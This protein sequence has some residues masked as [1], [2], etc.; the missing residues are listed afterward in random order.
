MRSFSYIYPF[1]PDSLQGPGQVC[2][3]ICFS[4]GGWLYYLSEIGLLLV[5]RTVQAPLVSLFFFFTQ[6]N[7]ICCYRYV[8][9]LRQVYHPTIM[10]PSAR[11][12][13]DNPSIAPRE[14]PAFKIIEI[15]FASSLSPSKKPS[16]YD[17]ASCVVWLRGENAL[18]RQLLVFW[19]H[20]NSF[21]YLDQMVLWHLQS[22]PCFS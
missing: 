20:D 17:L 14:S 21:L 22:H 9:T 2:S 13:W 8:S 5:F 15:P 19:L 1:I 12:S 6:L 3:E 16:D 18:I 10:I 4:W 7:L 11:L